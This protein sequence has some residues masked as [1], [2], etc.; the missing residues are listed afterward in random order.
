MHV[1]EV[2]GRVTLTMRGGFSL[3]ERI[4]RGPYLTR[5]HTRKSIKTCVSEVA[6]SARECFGSDEAGCPVRYC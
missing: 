5:T 1:N 3:V 6:R 2:F 4:D